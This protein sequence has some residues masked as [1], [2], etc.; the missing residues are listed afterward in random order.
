MK[1][2]RFRCLK[3][4]YE[5]E[6]PEEVVEMLDETDGGDDLVPPRFTCEKCDGIMEPIN[7]KTKDGRHYMIK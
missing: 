2:V 6:I 1:T 5:E 3:C 4:G 7:W